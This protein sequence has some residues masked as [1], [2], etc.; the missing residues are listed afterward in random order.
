MG[1]QQTKA[2]HATHMPTASWRAAPRTGHAHW[3]SILIM[4]LPLQVLTT[5]FSEWS[6][7][8]NILYTYKWVKIPYYTNNM[9]NQVIS[10]AQYIF[11]QSG[12]Q[13]LEVYITQAQ[14]RRKKSHARA[15]PT[16]SRNGKTRADDAIVSHSLNWIE[17]WKRHLQSL[18]SGGSTK[19]LVIHAL[20]PEDIYILPRNGLF[21]GSLLCSFQSHKMQK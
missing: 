9:I 16:F 20:I 12:R 19:Y 21:W 17:F 3:V 2:G 1:H 14:P 4:F 7:L 10:L 11:W 5:H 15:S 6:I 13:K 18:W 8:K